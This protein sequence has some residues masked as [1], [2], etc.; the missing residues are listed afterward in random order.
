MLPTIEQKLLNLKEPHPYYFHASALVI[1]VC[2]K[3]QIVPLL[4]IIN[5]YAER[6]CTGQFI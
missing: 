3:V 6:L 4:T 1:L 5:Y 2:Q